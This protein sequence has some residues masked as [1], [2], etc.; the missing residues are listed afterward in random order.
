M[1]VGDILNKAGLEAMRSGS[2]GYLG[3][4]AVPCRFFRVDHCRFFRRGDTHL[5]RWDGGAS[6]TGKGHLAGFRG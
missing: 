4:S 3:G 1:L 6:S 5:L 2:S